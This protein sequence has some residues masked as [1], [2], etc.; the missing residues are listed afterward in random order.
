MVWLVSAKKRLVVWLV[1]AENGLVSWLVSTEKGLISGAGCC[2][3]WVRVLFAYTVFPSSACISVSLVKW[4]F[5][6]WWLVITLETPH[7][8]TPAS[9]ARGW[10]Q[11]QSGGSW[12][13][14]VSR[15]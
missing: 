11:V 12:R 9:L 6:T 4:G 13:P 7:V 5:G 15:I 2:R 14:L 8:L 3:L 1:S 10:V